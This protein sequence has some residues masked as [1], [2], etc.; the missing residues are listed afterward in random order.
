MAE[1]E[2]FEHHTA[3]PTFA[4]AAREIAE[5]YQRVFGTDQSWNEGMVCHPCSRPGVDMKWNYI[6]APETCPHCG[7]ALEHY[8]PVEEVIK[9]MRGEL[10][11]SDATCVVARESGRVVG[12]CWGYSLTA[13]ELDLH[14]N[15]GIEVT[16]RVPGIVEALASRYQGI[17]RFAYLDE[18]FVLPEWQ[19][20]KI[21]SLLF[22]ERHSRFVARGLVACTMRTKTNPPSSTYRWYRGKLGF[23]IIGEYP[24]EDK[25]VVM[26]KRMDEISRLIGV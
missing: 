19:G 1:I 16:V 2:L 7:G 18:I 4:D 26:A 13:E 5:C 11:K 8:W 25:R 6:G 12:S 10:S 9:D 21:G 20:K 22:R 24:D 17:P 14:L 23:E 15:N 3:T